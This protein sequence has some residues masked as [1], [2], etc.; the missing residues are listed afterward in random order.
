MIDLATCLDSGVT[1][2]ELCVG[3]G[4]IF[5]TDMAGSDSG[6]QGTGSHHDLRQ[7]KTHLPSGH[8]IAYREQYPRSNRFG[9]HLGDVVF[10]VLVL[11][12]HHAGCHVPC[13]TEHAVEAHPLRH[14]REVVAARRLHE[15]ATHG[16]YAGRRDAE[17]RFIGIDTTT[18]YTGFAVVKYASCFGRRIAF[19]NTLLHQRTESSHT[20]NLRYEVCVTIRVF[21]YRVPT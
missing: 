6:H 16:V 17:E 14:L 5:W 19:V 11:T 10:T 15:R 18:L 2:Y 9:Q 8:L 3:V 13:R 21:K 4:R 1:R 7:T 20:R 12:Q